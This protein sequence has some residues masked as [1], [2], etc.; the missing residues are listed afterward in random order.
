MK[1]TEQSI[2]NIYSETEFATLK[3]KRRTLL[4]WDTEGSPPSGDWATVLW[5][6]YGNDTNPNTIS[7]PKLVEEQS[8]V[9]RARYLAWIYELGETRINGKRL[10][11]HLELRQGF[12]YWWMT[13]LAKKPNYYESP[14]INVVVKCLAFENLCN[15][16]YRPSC[17]KL[18][19]D[20]ENNR[21]LFQQYCVNKNMEFSCEYIRPIL[22]NQPI[23]QSIAQLLPSRLKA[24]LFLFLSSVRSFWNFNRNEKKW[25]QKI[26]ST[27]CFFDIFVHLQSKSFSEGKFSSNYWTNLTSLLARLNIPTTWI[28]TYYPHQDIKSLK[29]ARALIQLFNK[30]NGNN[31]HALTDSQLDVCV[32]LKA[33]SHYLRLTLISLQLSTVNKLF[34]PARSNFN[35]WPLFEKNWYDSLIGPPAMDNC[36]SLSIY[37]SALRKMP[38]QKIGF[39]IQENQPWEM[40]LLYAWR[41]FGHG[42]IIGVPHATVRFWD[43][44]Y[45]YDSRTYMRVNRNTLPMPDIV[46]VNGPAALKAYLDGG[47][48]E[49]QLFEV[50][51]LRYLNLIE[52]RSEQT[53]E[54]AVGSPIRILICGDNITGSNEKLMRILE[55]AARDLPRDTRYIFKRHKA[56]FFDITRYQSLN[57]IVSEEALSKLLNECDVVVVGNFSSAAVDAY[58]KGLVVASMLDGEILNSSP[59]R[60]IKGVKYFTNEYELLE[61]IKKSRVC[62]SPLIEPYFQLDEKLPRWADLLSLNSSVDDHANS[63]VADIK[64]SLVK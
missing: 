53:N 7:I 1:N 38:R 61:I 32:S 62:E 35:F 42:K 2:Q 41:A 16:K 23:K 25:K 5:R 10:V 28:H 43:L 39:Y 3:N 24:I 30:H 47:Y 40:A 19:T 12:S 37:E 22:S 14:H 48:P 15:E 17:I 33:M 26:K 11:D 20:S 6:N 46:A 52:D 57:L 9:L 54:A 64:N 58:C 29:H 51:A 13:S 21:A 63:V 18:V 36:I 55:V 45:F 31:F 44:R 27:I 50:E 8:D 4:V 56:C 34:R 49:S 59:L 60:G